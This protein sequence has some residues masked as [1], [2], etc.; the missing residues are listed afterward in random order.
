MPNLLNSFGRTKT[1]VNNSGKVLFESSVPGTYSYT[2]PRKTKCGIICV[3]GGAGG[4]ASKLGYGPD[5]NVLWGNMAY[6]GGSGA[7]SYTER[8]FEKGEN[9]RIYVGKGGDAYHSSGNYGAVTPSSPTLYLTL[10]N[11]T[12]SGVFIIDA[13]IT[14]RILYAGPGEGGW[15]YLSNPDDP[16]SITARPSYG[17]NGTVGGN[18]GTVTTYG[19]D[20]VTGGASVYNGY[21]VGGNA[22]RGNWA[23]TNGGNGYVKIYIIPSDNI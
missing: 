5:G 2:F 9:I 19:I 10:V 13:Y 23:A 12:S 22:T 20:S 8:V 1:H 6:S 11:G 7:Y 17:G 14:T 18:S 3:G 4:F 16:N 15:W 21:G